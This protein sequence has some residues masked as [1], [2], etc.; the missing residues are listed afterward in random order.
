MHIPC[1]PSLLYSP[2]WHA[3]YGMIWS[4]GYSDSVCMTNT[5]TKAFNSYDIFYQRVNGTWKQ[6]NG[7]SCDKHNIT[8]GCS[9]YAPTGLNHPEGCRCPGAKQ[10]LCIIYGT[11]S[12]KIFIWNTRTILNMLMLDRSC[13]DSL[14]GF[15]SSLLNQDTIVF[16]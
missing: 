5:F 9:W 8:L 1:F 2:T 12:E 6:Y 11:Y 7:F 10:V 14:W 13:K 3:S 16:I 4:K 15:A